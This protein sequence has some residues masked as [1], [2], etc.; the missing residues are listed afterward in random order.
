[1]IQRERKPILGRRTPP[2]GRGYS[3]SCE[4]VGTRMRGT[5]QKMYVVIKIK[6]GKRWQHVS[7]K[8]TSPKGFWKKKNPLQRQVEAGK[9]KTEA[10]VKR[11]RELF[12]HPGKGTPEPKDYILG[13]D[14]RYITKKARAC[15]DKFNKS[16]G[17][18]LESIPVEEGLHFEALRIGQEHQSNMDA[19]RNYIATLT[20]SDFYD[21]E[22]YIQ[23]VESVLCDLANDFPF[24]AIMSPDYFGKKGFD[25]SWIP[26]EDSSGEKGFN[27]VESTEF[28]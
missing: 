15:Y 13:V 8:A 9:R 12:W 4:K 21:E 27:P 17:E 2:L 5:D 25:P 20:D 14:D 3:A 24:T 26:P 18:K 6:N 10:E 19:A 1:M 23:A 7:K 11:I 22:T 16:F 28:K